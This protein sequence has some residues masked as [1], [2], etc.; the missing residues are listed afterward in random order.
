MYNV[1]TWHILL[2]DIENSD[3]R[4]SQVPNR[5]LQFLFLERVIFAWNRARHWSCPWTSASKPRRLHRHHLC[6][7]G[8][9]HARM[10]SKISIKGG[11][12]VWRELWTVVRHA[13]RN[14]GMWS[15]SDKSATRS[16][17]DH[18]FLV[19]WLRFQF[20]FSGLFFRWKIYHH[21]TK[22]QNV[23]GHHWK[24]MA[25][26]TCLQWRQGG[27]PDVWMRRSVLDYTVLCIL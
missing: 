1:C 9:E 26:R 13:L 21:S 16:R 14:D 17:K 20:S 6:Q 27:K 23:D 8:P 25:E 19:F 15:F 18:L 3:V 4:F 11:Q 7:C 10:V 22:E 5:S 24:G 12:S 2:Q